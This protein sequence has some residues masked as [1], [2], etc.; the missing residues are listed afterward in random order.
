MVGYLF[1]M[2]VGMTPPHLREAEELIEMIGPFA[3]DHTMSQ[4]MWKYSNAMLDCLDTKTLPGNDD[5]YSEEDPALVGLPDATADIARSLDVIATPELQKA[6]AY[7]KEVEEVIKPEAKKIDAIKD[8]VKSAI[9]RGGGDKLVDE[10]GNLL[11]NYKAHMVIKWR[12]F[13]DATGTAYD[14]DFHT[15]LMA[16]LDVLDNFTERSQS[17]R[18]LYMK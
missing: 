14:S 12:D 5:I 17:S 16:H 4:E 15:A 11:A 6:I 1:V 2:P 8:Q 3:L 9:K 10:E 13:C 7:L 18:R